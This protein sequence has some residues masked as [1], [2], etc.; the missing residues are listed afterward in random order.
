MWFP[1]KIYHLCLFIDFLSYPKVWDQLPSN[2]GIQDWRQEVQ[3]M[4]QLEVDVHK[5]VS[6]LSL[7]LYQHLHLTTPVYAEIDA[8][9]SSG[10][11]TPIY[12]INI[13]RQIVDDGE[14]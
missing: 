11:Y 10:T 5:L 9:V 7:R 1:V 14:Q 3:I 13:L 4:K 2:A 12:I 6:S 8:L